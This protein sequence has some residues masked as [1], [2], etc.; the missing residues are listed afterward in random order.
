[1]ATFLETRR[2]A[3]GQRRFYVDGCRVT[4]ATFESLGDGRRDCFLT[5]ETPSHWRFY[6]CRRL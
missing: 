4:R 2:K 6:H 1:M 5:R 3:D